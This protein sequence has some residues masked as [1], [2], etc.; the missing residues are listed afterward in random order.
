MRLPELSDIIEAN[1]RFRRS[2][3]QRIAFSPGSSVINIKFDLF[4]LL[5]QFINSPYQLDC[6]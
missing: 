2:P 4:D 5:V 6:K 3:K 1:V